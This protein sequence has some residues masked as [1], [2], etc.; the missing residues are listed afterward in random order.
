MGFLSLHPHTW[1][2]S[3]IPGTRGVVR[4]CFQDI[5][6]PSGW[7]GMSG[8]SK[9]LGFWRLL[10]SSKIPVFPRRTAWA[11]SSSFLHFQENLKFAQPMPSLIINSSSVKILKI[12]LYS[13][14]K[15][16]QNQSWLKIKV[17]TK[18][19][20]T[21]NKSWLKM[22]VDSKLKLTKNEI[23]SKWKLTQNESW[24]KIKVDSK[25]KL[26][27]NESWLKIKVVSK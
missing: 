3:E 5:L 20:L 27:Q 19:K 23:D 4:N 8:M 15:L 25:W 16:N 9:K 26:P 1:Y 24:L 22:K 6:S 12:K 10:K 18:W 11:P 7:S 14:L 21:Q 2:L 17:D 13:K